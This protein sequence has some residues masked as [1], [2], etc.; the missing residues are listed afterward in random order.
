MLVIFVLMDFCL[1][2]NCFAQGSFC[3]LN[4][5]ILVVV[6]VAKFLGG[7]V[8]VWVKAD[9]AVSLNSDRMN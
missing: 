2:C 5:G 8:E 3:I 9:R 6:G 1:P 4:A 7:L